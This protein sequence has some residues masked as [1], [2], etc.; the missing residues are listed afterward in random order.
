MATNEHVTL[1]ESISVSVSSEVEMRSEN[2]ITKFA[3]DVAKKIEE[4]K[5]S[6]KET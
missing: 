3:A 2:L 1:G 5:V 4:K 6:K